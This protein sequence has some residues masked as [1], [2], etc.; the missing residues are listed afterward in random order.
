MI[1]SLNLSFDTTQRMVGILTERYDEPLPRPGDTLR[2]HIPILMSK[3]KRSSPSTYVVASL[4]NSIFCNAPN[5]KPTIKPTI[6]GQNYITVA[7][8]R[9]SS[10]EG[11][12]R[13]RVEGEQIIKYIERGEKF[14]C[15]SNSGKLKKLLFDTSGYTV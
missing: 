6:K 5:C 13:T 3:I 8:A 14:N 7:F 2:L 1:A 15:E 4:C 12:Y 10:W 9:N 11:I